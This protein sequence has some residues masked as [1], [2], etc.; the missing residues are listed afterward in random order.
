MYLKGWSREELERAERI[1][2]K[3]EDNKHPSIRKVEDSLYWFTLAIGIIGTVLLSLIL[4]PILIV[5]N[6]A[7]SY[8]LTAVFGFL[9]GA[10]III[11]VKDLHWLGRHH[12]LS[13][14]LIIPII[15]LFNFFIVVNKVNLLVYGIGFPNYH[16][17]ILLGVIY[18]VSF[19]IPYFLFLFFRGR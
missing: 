10:I 14:S 6:N 2:K 5:N 15:A 1:M 18:F 19:L 16:N 9:L 11:I 7:W 3:A 4:I 17:P 8:I 13:I 12:H